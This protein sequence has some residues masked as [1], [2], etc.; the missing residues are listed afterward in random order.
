MDGL[1]V[2]FFDRFVLQRVT[3]CD[4]SGKL[5]SPLRLPRAAVRIGFAFELLLKTSDGLASIG[6]LLI[7]FVPVTCGYISKIWRD[8]A[9]VECGVF[10]PLAG[11]F[12]DRFVLQRVTWCD[13]VQYLE[14]AVFEAAER[15]N[16]SAAPQSC[17]DPCACSPALL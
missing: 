5:S 1:R 14:C 9:R 17:V 10:G 3:S 4:T 11:P 6:N 13:I 16:S 2:P 15:C 12:F 7:G 8:M